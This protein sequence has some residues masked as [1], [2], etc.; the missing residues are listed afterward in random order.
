MIKG[1]KE[2]IETAK[3]SAWLKSVDKEHKTKCATLGDKMIA[4]LK[5]FDE[6]HA[7]LETELDEAP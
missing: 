4:S 6:D 5:K 2:I 7:K 3:W 1:I